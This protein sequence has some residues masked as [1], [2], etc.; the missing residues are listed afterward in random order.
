MPPGQTIVL[1]TPK[2]DA[3]FGWWRPDPIS[4]IKQMNKLDG[5]TC[6]IFRNEGHRLSSV[7]ILDANKAIEEFGYG[8]GP[9][10]LLTYVYDKKVRSTDKGA[11]FKAAGYVAISRSADGKKTLL[12]KRLTA[13]PEPFLT[14]KKINP[15][16]G[17]P[18][19]NIKISLEIGLSPALEGFL[20]KV[21]GSG[22]ADIANR[23]TSKP[24]APTPKQVQEREALLAEGEEAM[25]DRV[26]QDSQLQD[27]QPEAQRRTRRTKAQMEADASSA[28]SGSTS[29]ESVEAASTGSVTANPSEIQPQSNAQLEPAGDLAQALG[30]EQPEARAGVTAKA[31][32]AAKMQEAMAAASPKKVQEKMIQHLNGAKNL[33]SL[34]PAL[35]DVAIGLFD[36]I[37]ADA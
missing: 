22:Q 5:W 34:D 8:C 25:A 10:G 14:F 28:A 23:D 26:P 20:T 9:D 31:D 2:G 30:A 36:G 1:L 15:N 35:Y 24:G 11:C 7:L 3:V 17:R 4:G 18:Y 21:L 12:Q 33:S 19:V 32:V 16:P 6:T 13:P 27:P 29:A 37:I